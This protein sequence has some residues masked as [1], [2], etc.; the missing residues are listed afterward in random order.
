MKSMTPE[1]IDD[2]WGLVTYLLFKNGICFNQLALPGRGRLTPP[3]CVAPAP[4]PFLPFIH[5]ILATRLLTYQASLLSL[6]YICSCA[7]DYFDLLYPGRPAMVQIHR[8]SGSSP[9]ALNPSTPL[10]PPLSI[11]LIL[12]SGLFAQKIVECKETV[13]TEELC[14]AEV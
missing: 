5:T 2:I 14:P 13:E 11:F 9:S 12:C 4:S 6:D 3:S 1:P 7:D 10:P 8:R